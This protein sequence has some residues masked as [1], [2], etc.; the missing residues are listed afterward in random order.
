MGGTERQFTEIARGLASS[1]WDVRVACLRAEGPLRAR[2]E[3]AGLEPWSCGAGSLKSPAAV[4]GIWRLARYIR[5]HRIGLVHSF[6]FYSNLYGVLAG[7]LARRGIIIASQ[8]D[9]GNLRPRAQQRI[10]RM[11]LR[12]AHYVLANSEAAAA[13]VRR[14]GG[15]RP[16]HLVVVPNGV[17]AAR[18]GSLERGGDARPV[19]V[20][21]TVTNLR[22]EKGLTDL[23]RATAL[24]R[25]RYPD[26]RLVIWGEGSLRPELEALIESLGLHQAVQLPGHTHDAGNAL[27]TMDAFILPSLSESC[28]N[29]LMEAM[30]VGLPVIASNTG[31]NPELL[32]DG[33]SGLLVRPADPT[34]LA[35]AMAHLMDDPGAAA[36]LGSHASQRARSKF[37]LAGM[38]AGIEAL[39]VSALAGD[40]VGRLPAAPAEA[41]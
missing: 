21:G 8:R 34:D 36:A 17:D 33:T 4:R 32:V 18:F 7:R 29:S 27:S 22:P 6:D 16:E 23:V 41:A 14:D 40:R 35:R 39:Y 11:M 15:I 38:L 30:A 24:L 31:G 12:L 19:R 1:R 20:F 13:E 25:G 2:L 5:R 3:E 9:L 37:S 28:S 26:I 10:N